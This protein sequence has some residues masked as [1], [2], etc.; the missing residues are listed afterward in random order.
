[1][2]NS[3]HQ[4]FISNIGLFISLA[5]GRW[6]CLRLV[7]VVFP[8][9][10]GWSSGTLP[11]RDHNFAE[12]IIIMIIIILMFIGIDCIS[13]SAFRS[14]AIQ[15]VFV[16]L[17]F[18]AYVGIWLL[19]GPAIR[20]AN[21]GIRENRFAEESLFCITFKRFARI[22]S[23]LRF[24]IFSPPKRDS[25]KRGSVRKPSTDLCASG[26]LRSGFATHFIHA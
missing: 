11:S 3:D 18:V 15:L 14:F 16:W 4:H 2:P 9:F 25:K 12:L 20:N 26:H 13:I 22:A 1:M 19:D 23:N 7:Q 17:L 10:L 8:W 5:T 24:A 21:R 6:V